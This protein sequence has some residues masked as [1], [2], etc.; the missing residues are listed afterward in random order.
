MNPLRNLLRRH[1]HAAV[2]LV[3]LALATK[4]LLPAGFMPVAQGK[5]LTMEIC[6]DASG[7]HLVKQVT[8]PVHGKA[9]E[10][11]NGV[12][13]A[14]GSCPFGALSFAG[15]AGAEPVQLAAA[16]AFVLALGTLAVAALPARLS[17]HLR[18]PL[19]GPPARA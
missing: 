3:V 14:D 12:A 9:G 18:P 15:L 13:K 10:D 2:L 8:I 1:R 17:P 19:R 11:G 7:A 16:L 6:G 4:A 5:T